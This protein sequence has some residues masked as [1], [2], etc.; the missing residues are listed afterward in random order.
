MGTIAIT[1][2]TP[3]VG[4][5][6]DGSGD[7]SAPSD[8]QMREEQA[9]RDAVV[10]SLVPFLQSL[11]HRP[12]RRQGNVTGFELLGAN[13]WSNLNKYLLLLSVDIGGAGLADELAAALPSGSSV[14]VV[15]EFESLQKSQPSQA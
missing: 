9:A 1:I 14:S 10:N 3:P 6:E 12:A 2:K 5:L 11:P 13:T 4:A 8:E 7:G 15:G